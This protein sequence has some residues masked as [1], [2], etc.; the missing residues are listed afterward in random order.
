MNTHCRFGSWSRVALLALLGLLG[1]LMVSVAHAQGAAPTETPDAFDAVG[2]F[3][4][5]IRLAVTTMV[6]DPGSQVR[7]I[8]RT[9][10]LTMALALFIW[11]AVGWALRGFD[12]AD[13]VFTAALITTCAGLMMV[14]P[15]VLPAVFDGA[16]YIGAALMAGIAGVPMEAGENASI[17]TLIMRMMSRWSFAPSCGGGEGLM[18]FISKITDICLIT[19]FGAVFASF[20]ASII[21]IVIGI[22]A[23]IV[24][25]WGFWGFSL[26]L[27][28][29]LI[30]VPFMLYERLQF[31]FDGWVKFFFGFLIYVIVARVN[32]ALVACVLMQY[33]GVG[34]DMLMAGNGPQKHVAVTSFGSLLGMQMFL[35]VGIF[36][37]CATGSFASAMVSG[38]GGGG[39]KFGQMARAA[40]A[41]VGGAAVAFTT[42]GAAVQ[43]GRAAAKGGASMGGIAKA[44]GA[45]GRDK[46]VATQ[47]NNKDFQKGY[48]VGRETAAGVMN[49]YARGLKFGA[50]PSKPTGGGTATTRMQRL[51]GAI[52]GA[53][54]GAS[55]AAR[56]TAAVSLGR[57]VGDSFAAQRDLKGAEASAVR[58]GFEAA[59]YLDK[60]KDTGKSMGKSTGSSERQR[61]EAAVNNLNET[62]N[63]AKTGDE[64]RQASSELTESMNAARNTSSPA[65]PDG[66]GA[67]PASPPG[68]P[69]SD[70]QAALAQLD[71]E[72]RDRNGGYTLAEWDTHAGTD[73]DPFYQEAMAQLDNEERERNGGRTLA[74]NDAMGG[75]NN[76]TGPPAA[77]QQLNVQAR[78]S[79]SVE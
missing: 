68:Q 62:L 8:S 64:V 57:K 74:E 3:E 25:V 42:T 38:A 35:G 2:A 71:N 44:A 47:K 34:V 73:K 61:V 77:P 10:F 30:F 54:G 9:L 7:R 14:L 75:T 16:L 53:M 22:A 5:Q 1:L 13:M 11:K 78:A 18:G 69:V 43:G 45:A 29:G 36:T 21:A 66:G 67:P 24:D 50:D 76:D 19:N 46:F 28:T 79:N 55:A 40:S 63:N 27:A 72:E 48:A 15:A 58:Q 65:A 26:A 31:L 60:G 56:T 4:N 37:L 51:Q 20:L 33:L 52:G 32:L 39:V 23:L 49:G 41:F 17:P 59:Q 12:L 70:E 6:Q